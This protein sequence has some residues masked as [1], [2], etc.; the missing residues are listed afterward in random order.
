MEVMGYKGSATTSL[1]LSL[2]D[3]GYPIGCSTCAKGFQQHLRTGRQPVKAC[4]DILHC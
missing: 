2:G 4:F 3:K 1:D